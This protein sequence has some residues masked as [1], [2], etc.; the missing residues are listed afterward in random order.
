MKQVS[1][2]ALMKVLL[3]HVKELYKL[4]MSLGN[5]STGERKLPKPVDKLRSSNDGD[6]SMVDMSWEELQKKMNL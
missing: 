2:K 5:Q 3:D 6:K 1:A 4:E